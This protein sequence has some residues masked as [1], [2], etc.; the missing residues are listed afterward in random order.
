MATPSSTAALERMRIHASPISRISSVRIAL[1]MLDA[2]SAPAARAGAA[3]YTHA[4]PATANVNPRY[5][6]PWIVIA[7]PTAVTPAP[8]RINALRGSIET[9]E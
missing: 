3:A 8:A 6:K 9:S 1:T 7:V 2:A 5:W 4:R